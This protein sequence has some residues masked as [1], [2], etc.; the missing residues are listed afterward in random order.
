[1]TRPWT[2]HRRKKLV[3]ESTGRPMWHPASRLDPQ[4]M[5]ASPWEEI[6]LF[7]YQ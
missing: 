5:V 3:V 6:L 1:M 7:P 4:G 2:A